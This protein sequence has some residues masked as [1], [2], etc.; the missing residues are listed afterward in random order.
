MSFNQNFLDFMSYYLTFFCLVVVVL[1]LF[2]WMLF[3]YAKGTYKL[4]SIIK[5]NRVLASI[6]AIPFLLGAIFLG[7]TYF[8]PKFSLNLTVEQ[9]ILG[10]KIF[11][12]GLAGTI[13]TTVTGNQI[14]ASYNTVASKVFT[15]ILNVTYPIIFSCHLYFFF[16]ITKIGLS[17]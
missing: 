1:N 2:S 14:E 5:I 16:E 17:Q 15:L 11:L 13:F 8:Y 9:V 7:L 10:Y 3:I 6:S 12:I 4:Y